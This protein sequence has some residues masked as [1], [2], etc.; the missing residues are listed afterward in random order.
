MASVTN[1]VM[2]GFGNIGQALLP[3]LREY[4]SVKIEIFDKQTTADRVEIAAEFEAGF[5]EC[6]ITS[7]NFKSV[8]TPHLQENSFVLNLA[9][10]VST[11][12]LI[13]L[14][15]SCKAFYLD[16]CI[17]PW[18]YEHSSKG[19]C[20]SNYDLR[21]QVYRYKARASN[22]SNGAKTAIIAH[23]ANPGFVSILVKKALIDM[24][25]L[26]GF[27][28]RPSNRIEWGE[29]AEKLGV[30]V[31][32]ISER[33]TQVSYRP[34]EK[35]EFVCTWSVDGL[36]T[37]ALQP[38]ELGWGTHERKIP[39]GAHLH[40]YGS[41]AGIELAESGRELGVK[42][43]SPNY[44]E[45]TGYLITHNESI[46]ISDY[47]TVKAKGEVLYRPTCYYAYHPC[48]DA[49]LSMKLLADGTEHSIFEKRVAKEEIVSGID[50]LGVFLI[51]EKF[52]SYWLGSNL[53]IGRA[54]K[55]AKYNNATSL[56]VVSSIV[57]G[58]LWAEA[59]DDQGVLE[60]EYLDWEFIYDKAKKYWEPIV[61]AS[62]N[63]T[64]NESS[65]QSYQFE[66]FLV[67]SPQFSVRQNI[68]NASAEGA[69][70]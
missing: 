51:S 16:T 3:L 40:D 25:K 44:L 65:I 29:L 37:E 54:R 18:E 53:S 6:E 2:V 32:Q 23:G 5:T 69:A 50:E 61:G 58:M 63:W 21:E 46:S 20:T 55:I 64:P 39:V 43:W 34:R 45:F 17:E 13:T 14:A 1:I 10:S 70:L 22:S 57:A 48:D 38:S 30:K 4:Y 15:Q 56:Q 28:V 7:L 35:N 12:D 60:S 31:I 27:S 11:I 26:N 68:A 41:R 66:D 33:D 67:K 36:I 9:V 59:N 49:I 52:D 42:T 24:A 62:T 47:F 19:I 8:I